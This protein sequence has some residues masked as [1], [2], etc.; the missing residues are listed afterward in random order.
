MGKKTER[1][2]RNRKLETAK[3]NIA[4]STPNFD[5]RESWTSR[6]KVGGVP[7]CV[8]DAKLHNYHHYHRYH[9]W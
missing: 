9:W 3:R 2:A 1:R 5:P 8:L 7:V 4:H 6:K